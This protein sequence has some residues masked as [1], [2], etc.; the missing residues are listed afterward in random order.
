MKFCRD[1]DLKHTFSGNPVYY[2]KHLDVNA[3]R[4][5]MCVIESVAV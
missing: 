5:L 1:F 3:L 2:V 4:W